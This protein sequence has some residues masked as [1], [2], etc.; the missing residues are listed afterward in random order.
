MNIELSID[1]LYEIAL[2]ICHCNLDEDET[3]EY[4]QSMINECIGGEEV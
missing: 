3:I 2:C 4:L 1:K